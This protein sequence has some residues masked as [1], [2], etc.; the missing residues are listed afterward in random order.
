MRHSGWDESRVLVILVVSR[1]DE[2]AGEWETRAVDVDGR[3]WRDLSLA[4]FEGER[5]AVGQDIWAL[6]AGCLG[7]G[8]RAGSRQD[9]YEASAAETDFSAPLLLCSSS[10]LLRSV[11]TARARRRDGENGEGGRWEVEGAKLRVLLT[12]KGKWKQWKDKEVH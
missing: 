3:V 12:E 5:E 6:Q 2:G 9:R 7:S 10:T 1:T 4:R 8:E 11:A